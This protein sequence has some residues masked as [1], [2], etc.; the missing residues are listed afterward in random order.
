MAHALRVHEFGGPD[1]LKWEEVDIASP[2]PGEVLVRNVAIGL[3]FLDIYYRSGRYPMPTPLV[4]GNEGAGIVEA[5]GDDVTAFSVGDRVGYI[6]PIGAYAERVIRPV[7][8]LVRLPNGI[9]EPVAASSLLKGVTAEYLLRRTY[10]VA[11]GETILVHAAAGGV[12]QILCQWANSIGATVIGT[13]GTA[14]KYETARNVGCSHVVVLEETPQFEKIV[15]E[16]T[17]G[18]GVQ[19]VY[20]GVGQT[21]FN[22]SLDCIAPL[23]MMAAFGASS[24]PIP[25]LDVQSLATKGSL[26]VTRPGIGTYTASHDALQAS[27]AALFDFIGS[28]AVKVSVGASYPLREG[29]QAHADLEARRLTGSTLLLP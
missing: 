12:G 19:V 3:N 15:R 7:N 1:A 21:T 9:S 24:G 5:V 29:A 23:G 26:F 16:I 10:K 22:Q 28:G 6:D 4:P 18:K 2:G 25:L 13:V 14:A 20:D 17:S 27:A 8:R 11:A